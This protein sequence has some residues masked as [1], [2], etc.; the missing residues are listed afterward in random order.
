MFTEIHHPDLIARLV[1]REVNH[2][3]IA[4][5]NPLLIQHGER[6]RLRHQISVIGDQDHQGGVAEGELEKSRNAAV[7]NAKSVL[8]CLDFHERLVAE[9]HRHRVAQEAVQVED[10]EI[11]LSVL[12]PRLVGKH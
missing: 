10:I 2:D 5:T 12:I 1:P 9:I 6:H 7:Q 3:V 11:Q 8:A 4:F